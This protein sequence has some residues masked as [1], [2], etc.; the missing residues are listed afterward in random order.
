MCYWYEHAYTCKHTTHAL[1]KFCA[2]GNLVQTPCKKKNIWQKIRMGEDCEDCAMPAH[3]I[4]QQPVQPVV[5]AKGKKGK[6]RM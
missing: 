4:V 6:K 1:G 5:G 2:A 3:K